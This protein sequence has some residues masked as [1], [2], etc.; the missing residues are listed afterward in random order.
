MTLLVGQCKEELNR[1]V[2]LSKITLVCIPAHRDR[3]GNEQAILGFAQ[4]IS[5]AKIA[6]IPFCD[7]D[8]CKTAKVILSYVAVRIQEK[9]TQFST[10][11]ANST[12]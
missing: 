8:I 2:Q 5:N 11:Y 1:L 6:A 4:S 10:F 9:R 7:I 3:F 12:K